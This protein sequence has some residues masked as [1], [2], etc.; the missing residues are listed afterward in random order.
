[1]G[2]KFA[3]TERWVYRRQG[4]RW[5]SRLAPF[6]ILNCAA[7][8]AQLPLAARLQPFAGECLTGCPGP[9]SVIAGPSGRT[10]ES[11][12]VLFATPVAPRALRARIMVRW[13]TPPHHFTVVISHVRLTDPATSAQLW[14]DNVRLATY[15]PGGQARQLTRTFP[16]RDRTVLRSL[17]YTVRH[18]TQEAYLYWRAR[19]QRA[20]AR[21]LATFLRHNHFTPG[22]DLRAAIFGQAARL[23]AAMPFTAVGPDNAYQDC[24]HLPA[25]RPTAYP[26]TSKVC[27]VGVNTYL[28]AGRADPFL[29]AF[30]ALQTLNKYANPSQRYPFLTALDVGGA[31]PTQTA[32]HLQGLWDQLGHGIPECSP[33]GCDTTKASGLRTFAFGALET[34]LAY[35]FGEA[36]RRR[37]ADAAATAA[38]AAQIRADGIINAPNRTWVRP[39][40]AGAYPI[41]W[42]ARYQFVPLS[43]PLKDISDL[44]SMPP[45]YTGLIVSDSETTFDGWAF[46]TTYR[47]ARFNIDCA[48]IPDA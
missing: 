3:L 24:S 8:L 38:I 9:A 23:P 5:V 7:L 29:Q 33:L 18:A 19:G 43:G 27:L 41:Y 14:L 39:A 47:C 36:G 10:W 4:G 42:S 31:T 11:E 26:Y 28:L 35:R 6:W 13:T 2:W 46:L 25:P 20:R 21:R 22:V 16:D 37:Y 44:L 12:T 30:E 40:Q 45:E 32:D 34:L 48:E 15:L 1:M 17:R